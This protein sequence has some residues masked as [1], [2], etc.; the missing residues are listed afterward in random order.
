MLITNTSGW[1]SK[2][3]FVEQSTMSITATHKLS[4]GS[5]TGALLYPLV[6]DTPGYLYV[7]GI[8][9][10]YIKYGIGCLL[11]ADSRCGDIYTE[12][13]IDMRPRPDGMYE[14][15]A[16]QYG[17]Y[18]GSICAK[19]DLIPTLMVETSLNAD[20]LIF[21]SSVYHPIINDSLQTVQRSELIDVKA[22]PITGFSV[23]STTD[24]GPSLDSEGSIVVDASPASSNTMIS[25]IRLFSQDPIDAVR[26]KGT[27]V[28]IIP[29]IG[30]RVRT[31]T[32]KYNKA[33][34]IGRC[35]DLSIQ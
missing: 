18:C 21:T 13:R 7:S 25:E 8:S 34:E 33:I 11:L 17:R 15:S 22:N 6:S 28:S 23:L 32:N 14:G 10:K 9:T 35:D 19:E 5:I 30:S 1:R 16:I 31:L 3:P 12:I 4:S 24:P 29:R 2:Y 27:S 26:I 20:A